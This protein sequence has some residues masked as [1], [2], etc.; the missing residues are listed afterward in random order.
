VDRRHIFSV[1]FVTMIV[2][3]TVCRADQ[4]E[5]SKSDATR[6]ISVYSDAVRSGDT[7]S[8]SRFYSSESRGR[9][10]FLSG[11]PFQGSGP[12]SLESFQ[13]FLENREGVIKK[14]RTELDHCV[15]ELDWVLRAGA[16]P[17]NW[18]DRTAME[19]YLVPEEGRLT[20][21]HPLDLL[22]RDWQAIETDLFIF[23]FPAFLPADLYRQEMHGMDEL[24]GQIQDYLDL[25][26]ASKVSIYRAPDANL[27]G[28]LVQRGPSYAFAVMAWN[29]IV[30]TAFVNPHEYVH[31][32]TMTGGSFI[33]AAFSEGL[34]VALGGG[35]WY[36]PEFS[37]N[38]ARNLLDDPM[39]IPIGEVM[40]M[41][42]SAFLRQAEVTYHEAGAFVKYLLERYGW[43]DL[44]ELRSTHDAGHPVAAAFRQ[45]YGG[46]LE[47]EE[48]QWIQH[49]RKQS[50][51]C[52]GPRRG[53]E[54][55]T[56]ITI[57][58]PEGDDHGDGQYRYPTDDS[59]R[60]GAFDLTHFSVWADTDRVYF[61][62]GYRNLI[63]PVVNQ[64]T[65]HVF[66]PA[67]TIAINRGQGTETGFQRRCLG[68]DFEG[69][70]GYDLRIDVGR[71]VQ[72][73]N[74]YNRAVFSSGDARSEISR[75]SASSLAFS[76]PVEL[77][78]RPQH[79]WSFFVGV[80]LASD[81]GT[82][83]LRI[84]PWFLTPQPQPYNIGGGSDHQS[85]PR[86]IDI[87][88]PYGRSQE[89]VLS[90]WRTSPLGRA[91]VPMVH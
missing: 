82:G 79:D 83:F 34:A 76:L 45:V 87:L 1:A 16:E 88:V 44:A 33:N 14:V 10:G 32:L 69:N 59:F 55:E 24:S 19:Y 63:E 3:F 37:V 30:T 21:I 48:Q 49:L 81:V 51:P 27:C 54:T 4:L 67:L 68:V 6:F 80:Y 89:E 11:V 74:G 90:S 35:A 20:L 60:P 66:V 38:Q 31:L 72:V 41:P 9:P 57:K 56:I 15:I 53:A 52:L 26:P 25:K 13:E 61:E 77:C 78:G 58:D 36:T 8:L 2:A 73:V 64:A 91:Q 70:E 12:V 7:L 50:L 17:D 22:T 18:P 42:D 65:G 39:Y 40:V 47:A 62:I 84:I 75:Q 28:K 71:C 29:L 5:V 43:G 23:H 46:T 85:K 86:F